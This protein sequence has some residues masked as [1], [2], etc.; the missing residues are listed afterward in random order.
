MKKR[1]GVSRR[2]FCG[3]IAA[4]LITPSLGSGECEKD[5]I[6]RKR[7]LP[8]SGRIEYVSDVWDAGG[9]VGIDGFNKKGYWSFYMDKKTGETEQVMH[10]DYATVPFLKREFSSRRKTLA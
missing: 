6:K 2:S 3:G 10:M 1:D 5:S 7:N 8:E 4:T 9:V